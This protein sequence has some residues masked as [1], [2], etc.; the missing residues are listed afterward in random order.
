MNT[1]DIIFLVLIGVSV[2]YSLVRGLVR[3]IF[4]FLAVILGFLGA[5]YGYSAV[6]PW[7][8][9]VIANE[10]LA[11]I[12][13]FAVLFV[14]IALLIGLL[15][16][17]LSRLIHQGGLGWADRMAGAAFGF[18]KAVIVVAIV[19]LIL[20]AF[21]PPKSKILLESKVSPAALAAARG[22]SFLVPEELRN[23]YAQK[24]R[25]LK[26]YWTLQEFSWEKTGT[27]GAPKP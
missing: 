8:K 14:L 13:A 10:T 6:A 3:E 9:R 26:K 17:G 18:L 12:L 15:G 20:T 5:S 25:D 19:V 24:E 23:L 16:K 11:Q 7:L 4:S 22:L 21:L 27:K 1:L 2:I